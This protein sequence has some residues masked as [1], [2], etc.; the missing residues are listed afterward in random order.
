MKPRQLVGKFVRVKLPSSMPNG[1]WE[2]HYTNY[3]SKSTPGKIYMVAAYDADSVRLKGS[4]WHKLEVLELCP[5]F[6]I[7]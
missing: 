6:P 7:I 3:S 2:R 5:S 1:A 4:N